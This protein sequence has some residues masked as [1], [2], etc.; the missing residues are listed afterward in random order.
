VL[1]RRL[2]SS[3]AS[4]EASSRLSNCDAPSGLE[5]D[6]FRFVPRLAAAAAAEGVGEAA[7]V[8]ESA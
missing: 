8:V 6:A 1:R 5:T 4:R 7:A 2:S 3:A